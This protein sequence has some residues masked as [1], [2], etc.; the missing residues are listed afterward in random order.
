MAAPG[1]LPGGVAA[2]PDL[3]LDAPPTQT[4]KKQRE[5][6]IGNLASGVE[7]G[8]MGMVHRGSYNAQQWSTAL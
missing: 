3:A 4:N 5:L 7:L 8:T 1:T 6:Y 2:N